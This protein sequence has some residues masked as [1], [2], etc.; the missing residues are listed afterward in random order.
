MFQSWTD[1]KNR[2][3]LGVVKELGL[4]FWHRCWEKTFPLEGPSLLELY[5]SRAKQSLRWHGDVKLRPNNNLTDVV[6]II[7]YV[8]FLV[9]ML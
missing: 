1:G 2:M 6:F 4:V 3:L 9:F 8:I 5:N 7:K